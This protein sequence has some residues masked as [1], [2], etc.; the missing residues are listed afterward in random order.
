[1]DILSEK[2][3]CRK[4][5]G[6]RNM[7]VINTYEEYADEESHE[8]WICK[9]HITKCLGCDSISF[10][11]D[12][13][14]D[15]TSEWNGDEIVWGRLYTV[16]PPEPILETM[17]G[18]FKITPQ[19]FRNVPKN[20]SNLYDQI[21][22]SYSFKHAILCTAGLR[23]LLEGICSH[24]DIKGGHLYDKNGV[25]LP[26]NKDIIREHTS[27]GGRIFG[28]FENG[29]ILLPQALVLQGVIKFG[30]N[31][32]HNIQSPGYSKL[33]EIIEIINRVLYDIY[34]LKHHDFIKDK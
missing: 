30:N 34:E 22:E 2:I 26:D 11:E 3:Y 5:K 15:E 28:L 31:A 23:T 19:E 1:M 24:L 18:P 8:H 14:G 17:E 12:F 29:L 33:F 25:K 7:S 32:I 27:L 21:I 9:Y 10:V 6:K 13:Q 20:L 4:C 16:Y